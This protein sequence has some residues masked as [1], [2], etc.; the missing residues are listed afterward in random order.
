MVPKLPTATNVF[1][2]NAALLSQFTVALCRWVQVVASAE[3][4]SVP[5]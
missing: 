2:V 3:V 1:L 5:G 4:N